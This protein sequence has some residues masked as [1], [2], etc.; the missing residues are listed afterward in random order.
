[1]CG[2]HECEDSVRQLWALRAFELDELFGGRRH[3]EVLDRGCR[4]SEVLD[5]GCRPSVEL[6]GGCSQSV[7]EVQLM[8]L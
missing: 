6:D 4:H 7:E 3:S 8:G 2:F 5:G 1:M